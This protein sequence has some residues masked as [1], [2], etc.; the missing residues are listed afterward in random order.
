MLELLYP[1][2]EPQSKI[3]LKLLIFLPFKNLLQ[4]PLLKGKLF[5]C[6]FY[7]YSLSLEASVFVIIASAHH[8]KGWTL[9]YHKACPYVFI[10]VI[11]G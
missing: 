9:I 1:L 5:V 2:H 11:V 4:F 6:T 10:V 3:S 8:I 7:L